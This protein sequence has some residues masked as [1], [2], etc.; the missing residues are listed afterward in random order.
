MNSIRWT[1]ANRRL[2]P[3]TN[4][5]NGAIAGVGPAEHAPGTTYLIPDRHH[6][7]MKAIEPIREPTHA[8]R[9]GSEGSL[10]QQNLHIPTR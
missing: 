10:A 3:F 7:R 6:G 8:F 9:W 2:F 5:R 4:D 1:V